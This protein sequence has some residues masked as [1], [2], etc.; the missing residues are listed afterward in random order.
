MGQ[1]Y[2]L[3]VVPYGSCLLQWR[4]AVR[5]KGGLLELVYQISL[6]EMVCGSLQKIPCKY[7]I[8][9]RDHIYFFLRAWIAG[10]FVNVLGERWPVRWVGHVDGAWGPLP[11]GHMWE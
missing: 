6:P 5:V 8:L 4:Y 9:T 11:V 2:D 10:R 7:H 3:I 1:Q